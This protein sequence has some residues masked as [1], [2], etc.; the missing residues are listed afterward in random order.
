MLLNPDNNNG[1]D[2]KALEA[3][4][5]F[6]RQPVS[7]SKWV[8]GRRRSIAACF[9]ITRRLRSSLKRT[10]A[11]FSVPDAAS[12][13]SPRLLCNRCVIGRDGAYAIGAEVLLLIVIAAKL[14]WARPGA[15][16]E[17]VGNG[18]LHYDT[19]ERMGTAPVKRFW[20][21]DFT[22]NPSPMVSVM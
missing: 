19:M 9:S 6:N 13:F 4:D 3:I 18:V 1:V 22:P 20:A 17:A 14:T 7:D 5:R 21:M 10:S 16:L 12:I 11:H 2:A 8:G 15:M